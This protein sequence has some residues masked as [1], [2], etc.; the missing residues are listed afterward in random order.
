MLNVKPVPVERPT[1]TLFRS[2]FAG[3]F[4]GRKAVTLFLTA[5]GSLP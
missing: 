2:C 1:K 3:H 4:P 5:V